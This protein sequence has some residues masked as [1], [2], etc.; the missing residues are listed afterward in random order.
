[1]LDTA[2]ILNKAIIPDCYPWP[3]TVLIAGI[4]GSELSCNMDP[5]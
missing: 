3:T 5:K 4:R 1:M 2:L